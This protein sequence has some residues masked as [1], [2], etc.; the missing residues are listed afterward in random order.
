MFTEQQKGFFLKKRGN[1]V[2]LTNKLAYLHDKRASSSF[3]WEIGILNWVK[4]LNRG[5]ADSQTI[6][7]IFSLNEK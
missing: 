6:I 5:R 1:K 4:F 7:F 2:P 3:K